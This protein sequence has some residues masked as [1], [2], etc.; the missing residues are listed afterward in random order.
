MWVA[1]G[2]VEVL[3]PKVKEKK[4]EG[5]V[6]ELLG[7]SASH[8]EF[9]QKRKHQQRSKAQN[10]RGIK[11]NPTNTGQSTLGSGVARVCRR[12]R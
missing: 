9:P 3:D 1:P 5:T 8:L 11:T 6:R 12:S 10:L 4:E 7:L 2:S